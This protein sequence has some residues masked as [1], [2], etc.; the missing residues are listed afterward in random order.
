LTGNWLDCSGPQTELSVRFAGRLSN[1]PSQSSTDSFAQTERSCAEILRSEYLKK[2]EAFLDG[3]SGDFVVQLVDPHRDLMAIARDGMGNRYLSYCEKAGKLAASR[4]EVG[5]IQ[6]NS[7]RLQ[8]CALRLAEF[9]GFEELSGSSTFFRDI[10]GLLPGEMLIAQAGEIRRRW[11]ARPRLDLRIERAH[12]EEYVEEFAQLLGSSV[13]T[14]LAGF[15][16]AAILTSG[17]LDST[18]L[19]AMAAGA[20]SGSGDRSP[21]TALSWRISD[22]RGDESRFVRKLADQLGIDIEWINCD[23]ATPFSTLSEW[24]VHPATP[25]Q[26]AYRW[27]HQRSYARAAKLGHRVVLT[28]FCGDALY[29]QG[30]QWFWSL[31]A[32]DGPGSAID[33]LREVAGKIGWQR[34]VRSHVFGPCLPRRRELRRELPRY[35]TA[36][37][38]EALRSRPRWPPDLASAR[39][40]RQAE[41]VLAL[42]DAHGMNVERFYLEPFGLEQRTP[43]RDFALVQFMLAVPDHLLQQGTE[44]RPVLR[45]AVKGLIPEEI[46]LRRDKGAF[47]DVLDRGLATEKMRWAKELLLDP[48][49]LWRGFIEESSIRSWIESTPTDSWG[50]MGYLHA[51]YGELWRRERAGLPRPSA[52]AVD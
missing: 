52:D 32:A 45:A 29:I 33:R 17:G 3:L 14:C 41:R 46:R 39:R 47:H 48:D 28:G 12:W 10:H 2:G 35:L 25:E 38:K 19:A 26:T 20:L 42:L 15:D 23:D 5:L 43:L 51:I 44:T 40:P 30:R 22:P 8:L 21:L 37:A 1:L 49:A 6:R 18:P 4:D 9:F 16:R 31:L 34:T 7:S 36:K 50:R 27:F 24:P 11:L 13:R